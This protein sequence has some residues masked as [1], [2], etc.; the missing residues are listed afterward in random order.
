VRDAR[1]LRTIIS[2]A[3]KNLPFFRKTRSAWA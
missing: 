3:G 2:D 1:R